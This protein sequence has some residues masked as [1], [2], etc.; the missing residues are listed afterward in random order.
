M[1]MIEL[2]LQG[3]VLEFNKFSDTVFFYDANVERSKGPL[4]SVNVEFLKDAIREYE[5]LSED[6]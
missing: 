5:W 4:V 1:D 6:G 2:Q 3:Y